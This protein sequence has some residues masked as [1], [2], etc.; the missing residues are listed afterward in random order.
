[1]QIHRFTIIV[2]GVERGWGGWGEGGLSYSCFLTARISHDMG[3]EILFLVG[4]FFIFTDF[5]YPRSFSELKKKTK[6]KK[7]NTKG[8]ELYCCC[9]FLMSK[10][11][12]IRVPYM[13]S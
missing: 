12:Y 10:V 5:L 13:Q 1:M 7:T 4:G 11:S 8:R 9:C 6:K 2:I 3:K